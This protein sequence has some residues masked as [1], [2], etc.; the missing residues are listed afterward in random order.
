VPLTQGFEQ[1]KALALELKAATG[2]ANADGL[3][4]SPR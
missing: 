2:A 4:W 3:A 1:R